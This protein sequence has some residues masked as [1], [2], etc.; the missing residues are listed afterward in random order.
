M[1]VV[2]AFCTVIIVPSSVGCRLAMLAS[3]ALQVIASGSMLF[4]TAGTWNCCGPPVKAEC[5]LGERIWSWLLAQAPAAGPP[6]VPLFEEEESEEH[7]EV[8]A[9]RPAARQAAR[10]RR[11]ES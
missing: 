9:S 8:S 7:A 11:S 1:L 5:I 3:E 10:P 6:G 2:P 4:T